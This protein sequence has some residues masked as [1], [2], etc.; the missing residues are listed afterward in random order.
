VRHREK[1]KRNV[2]GGIQKY[3]KAL[4]VRKKRE[5]ESLIDVE[6][7]YAFTWASTS[8]VK[9]LKCFKS[10]RTRNFLAH[11]TTDSMLVCFDQQKT[12]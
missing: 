8:K 7:K 1:E 5:R 10:W 2:K 3:K 11:N 6:V 4:I 12:H 9:I